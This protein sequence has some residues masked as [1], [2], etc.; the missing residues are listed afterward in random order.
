MNSRFITKRSTYCLRFTTTFDIAV[1]FNTKLFDYY[2]Y[3]FFR[4]PSVALVFDHVE[5]FLNIRKKYIQKKWPTQMTIFCGS[6]HAHNN[7]VKAGKIPKK[8]KLKEKRNCFM[9][10][11]NIRFNAQHKRKFKSEAYIQNC[12]ANKLV[13]TLVKKCIKWNSYF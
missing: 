5:C 3:Y 1:G 7:L 11:E 2:Y 10:V 13:V 9:F 4:W 6:S 12:T 8:K